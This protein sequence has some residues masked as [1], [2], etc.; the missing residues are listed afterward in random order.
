MLL[1]RR[2]NVMQEETKGG[3]HQLC[4]DKNA[5]TLHIHMEDRKGLQYRL[6]NDVLF[7]YNL[8]LFMA[9]FIY[10]HIY[11]SIYLFLY[12]YIYLSIYLF[13][14][15]FIYL[16]IYWS[17]YLFIHLFKHLFIHSCIYLHI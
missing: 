4:G 7:R 6:L 5:F 2:K 11:L 17:I 3:E 14:P 16:Y 8:Y 12:L 1:M 9:V 13:I 10:L 15:V